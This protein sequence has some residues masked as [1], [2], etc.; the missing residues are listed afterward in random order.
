[1][2]FGNLILAAAIML[3]SPVLGSAEEISRQDS[4]SSVSESSVSQMSG[5]LLGLVDELTS[6]DYL[7]RKPSEDDRPYVDPSE[8]LG[9]FRRAAMSLAIGDLE[10]AATAAEK[11]QYELVDFYDQ[12]SK[13]NYYLLRENL[14]QLETVRGWGA[15]LLNPQP[16]I[17]AIVEAPH[18]LGDPNTA[19]IATRIF[20]AGAR[21]FLLAGAHRRK[22]DLPDLPGSPFHQVHTA[23]IGG[24]YAD[25]STQIP[26]LQVHGYAE[27]R[28]DFPSDAEVI[29]STG[30]GQL[31]DPLVKLDHR[32]DKRGFPSYVYNRLEKSAPRNQGVNGDSAGTRFWSLAATKNEQGKVSRN[33]GGAF[34]HIELESAVRRDAR[35]SREAAEIIAATIAELLPVQ[36]EATAENL[37]ANLTPAN[38]PDETPEVEVE[39]EVDTEATVA[40]TDEVLVASTEVGETKPS[41]EA[42]IAAFDQAASPKAGL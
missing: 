7:L 37:A 40:A 36:L 1:M 35:R 29:L 12:E 26:A 2:R 17:N 32:F 23:W 38:K 18:P 9:Q 11:I 24:D 25:P 30:G 39:V 14:N 8:A 28:H 21:G 34:M 5:T 20:A 10:N 6:R 42:P 16:T 4:Q 19:T 3:V 41:Q 31:I 22:A 33:A 15:Y 13:Q 27:H